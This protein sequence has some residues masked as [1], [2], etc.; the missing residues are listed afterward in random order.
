MLQEKWFKSSARVLMLMLIQ[1]TN[2]RWV[3]WM[4]IN[5]S[6]SHWTFNHFSSNKTY[7]FLQQ[8]D[9]QIYL[10]K[11][12]KEYRYNVFKMPIIIEKINTFTQWKNGSFDVTITHQ[13]HLAQFGRSA[14]NA[15]DIFNTLRVFTKQP[16]KRTRNQVGMYE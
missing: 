2:L 1:C 12:V 11:F 10:L 6:A 13:K 7:K 4:S 15:V 8:Q 3:D 16:I 5:I 14:R 9:L